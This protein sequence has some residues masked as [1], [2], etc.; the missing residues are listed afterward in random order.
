[1]RVKVRECDNSEKKV[2]GGENVKRVRGG[3]MDEK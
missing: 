1:M 3:N 2:V